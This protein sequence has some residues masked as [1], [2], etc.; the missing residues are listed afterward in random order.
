MAVA[1]R[2]ARVAEFGPL[3]EGTMRA[4]DLIPAFA[5]SL[6]WLSNGSSE[7]H[8]KLVAEAEAIEDFDSEEAGFVL[9]E[10]FEALNDY[11]PDYGY[12]GA[13]EG[14]AA[15]YGFWFSEDAAEDVPKYG[16]SSEVPADVNECFIV[17]DHGNLTLLARDA[18]GELQEV[19]G[20]V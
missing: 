3:S 20:L 16:D 18:A 12:F 1:E 14:D 5:D 4:E 11:A 13:H 10:L 2:Q 9:D 7:A 19:W 8:S 6:E 17:N 15:C